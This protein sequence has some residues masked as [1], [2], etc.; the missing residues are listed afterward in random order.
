MKVDQLD[1]TL[2]EVEGEALV[3]TLAFSHGTVEVNTNGET[4]GEME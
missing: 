4:L 1:Q 3:N 2:A